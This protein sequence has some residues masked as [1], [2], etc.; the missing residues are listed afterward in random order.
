M[1]L[2]LAKDLARRWVTEA[3]ALQTGCQGTFYQR[4]EQ[5]VTCL[6]V[7]WQVAEEIMAAN[8][9]IDDA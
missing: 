5:V 7:V 8:P 3:A 9:E 1:L 6:P 4:T 2:R